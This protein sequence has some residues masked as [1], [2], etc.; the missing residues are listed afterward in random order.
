MDK[1]KEGVE[2]DEGDGDVWGGGGVGRKGRKLYLNY[3]KIQKYLIIK[4]KMYILQK[5]S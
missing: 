5:K 4:L 3:N 2:I 1:N